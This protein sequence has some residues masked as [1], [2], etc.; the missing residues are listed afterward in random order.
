MKKRNSIFLILFAL[1]LTVTVPSALGQGPSVETGRIGSVSLDGEWSFTLASN[2]MQAEKLARFHEDS[3]DSSE[4]KRIKVP[5]NWAVEGFEEP[6]YDTSS[7]AE[8]F[9][10]NRFSLPQTVKGER[11]VLHFD[12][13]WDSAEVW[14]NGKPLGRHDSGFTAFGF[15]VTSVMKPGAE[16]KLAVRVRQKTKDSSLD[17]NDDWC[18]GGIYRSVWMEFTPRELYIDRVEVSTKFDRQ[19][20]DSFLNV[21][22][23]IMRVG[24]GGRSDPSPRFELSANMSDAGGNDIQH[25]TFIGSVTGGRN[26]RDIFFSM[27]VKEP[28]QWTA[29]TPNLYALRLELRIDGKTI[30]SWDEK[31]GFREISTVGGVL[32]I[33][34]KPVK[35][36]GVCRHD[37]NPEVGRAT[38]REHWMKD[39][40][41]MKAANINAVRTSHYPPAEGFIRLCDELGLYVIDEIPTGYGGEN[42]DDPSFAGAALLRMHETIARDCNR[43]SVI[44]WSIGN[45][46]PVTSLHIAIARAAKGLD[47]TRPVLMPWHSEEELAPEIDIL[48]PHYNTAEQYDRLAATSTRP[49]VTTEYTHALGP[50]DFGGLEDRWRSLTQHPAGA[51]GMIWMWA[52]QGLIRKVRGRRVFDPIKDIREYK[53]EGSELIRQSDAGTDEIYDSHGIYGTDGI[54]D[55]DRTPQ[56]DYWETKAVYAPVSVLVDKVEIKADSKSITIPIRNDHDFIDL[57]SL[58]IRWGL[59]A[60][61]R[62]LASGDARLQA[63]PHVTKVLAVPLSGLPQPEPNKAYY[64]LLSFLR[65]DGSV[66]TQRSVRL[67]QNGFASESGRNVTVQPRVTKSVGKI[68]ISANSSRYEFDSKTGS[69]ISVEIN[70]KQVVTGAG[71]TVWRPLTICEAYQ[72]RKVL[73]D[74]LFQNMFP[75]LKKW[76]LKSENNAVRITA[77]CEYAANEK[78]TFL[79]VFTYLIRPDGR[80]R[81]NYS[82]TP[83]VE[84]DWLPEV[85][86]E[87]RVPAEM[88]QLKW[89]GLGPI[90]SVPNE[91]EAAIFG[92]WSAKAGSEY[93]RGTKSGIEWVELADSNGMGIRITGSP[94]TRYD[95]S[96]REGCRLKLLTAVTGRS[97]K[98]SGPERPE[99]KIDLTQTQVFKGQVE[100]G[101]AGGMGVL[102]P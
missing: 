5:S 9:Y 91:K 18:L 98:F 52:D 11:A 39:I 28:L 73:P 82:I 30:H 7:E 48:A 58:Q 92:L 19:Y 13:V 51:G 49:I 74:S 79:A 29:E 90:E 71:I 60:D 83:R 69:I 42:L 38:R 99:W 22:A 68:T 46:D 57:N 1:S 40:Q 34:G 16:N 44:I 6:V 80:L 35:L 26:G 88:D 76:E 62:E 96:I 8:G 59:M 100:I 81:I 75:V 94:F 89:L 33:N 17:T 86:I 63:Q 25:A 55:A 36:R 101:P 20:R 4:F 61:E 67:I 65:N 95:Y 24:R 14:L 66:I 27:P 85:G 10:L 84:G 3:Y 37:E 32:K 70:G 15:D 53:K 12:G 23:F 64:I 47:P 54:V 72:R 78:N 31:V 56:R 87:M 21:R 41:L 50:D 43:P 2:S 45:E 97:T 77:E 102:K 93:T